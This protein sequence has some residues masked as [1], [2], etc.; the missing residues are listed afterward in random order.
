MI[1]KVIEQLEAEV[2]DKLKAELEETKAA[3]MLTLL[4]MYRDGTPDAQIS[5]K[6]LGISAPSFYTLKSRL[7][8]KVQSTLFR[9]TSDDYAELLKN[10]AA[11]PYLIHNT[12]RESAVLLLLYL[13]EELRRKDKPG[14]LAQVYGAL[15][16]LHAHHNDYFHY[17]QLYNK[18]IA[19]FLALEK[20]EE[21]LTRFN[22]GMEEFLLSGDAQIREVMKLYVK[23]LTNLSRLYD[24]HRI[25]MCKYI[26][27]VSFAIFVEQSGEII[28]SD[29]T[30]QEVLESMQEQIA[31]YQDDPQYRFLGN[32]VHFLNFEYYTQLGLH[33]NAKPSFDALLNDDC[34]FL[35]RSHTAIVSRFLLTGFQKLTEVDNIEVKYLNWPLE[36][37]NNLFG[38]TNQV[39]FRTGLLFEQKKFVQANS[40]LNDFLNE[41]SFRNFFAAECAVRIF[42]ILNLLGAEKTDLAESQ[43]RSLSRKISGMDSAQSLPGAV[44]EWLNLLK[45]LIAAK[46]KSQMKAAAESLK[47]AL[48]D[49]TAVLRHIN[50]DSEAMKALMR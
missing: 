22:S 39:L 24:S 23:E 15:K 26:A 40:L 21:V 13:E 41:T 3:K 33:K 37:P 19:Y 36:D 4:G 25:Q 47:T 7:Q 9:N 20:T 42:Y 16:K 6:A 49:R 30:V 28:A 31:K 29:K 50:P 27:E 1:R 2:Y 5:A 10:L 32:V 14:D 35:Y 8:D 44:T 18:N 48:R 34:R 17:E 11:I 45:A 38:M 12:P 43:M 46:D